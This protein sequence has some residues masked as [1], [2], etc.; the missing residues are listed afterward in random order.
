MN[1]G[2]SMIWKSVTSF[3][4]LKDGDL[5]SYY[6]KH[7][8]IGSA[9]EEFMNSAKT[10]ERATNSLLFE[11]DTYAPKPPFSIQ[12]TCKSFREGFNGKEAAYN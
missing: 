11:S 4:S 2:Y 6:L 8:D 12:G 7:G 10:S 9:I 1:V 3:H 5:S